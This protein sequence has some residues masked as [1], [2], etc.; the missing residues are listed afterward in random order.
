VIVRSRKK[1]LSSL[2]AAYRAE[3]ER[4]ETATDED[5]MSRLDFEFQRDQVLMEAVLD[6]REALSNLQEAQDTASESP[7]KSLLEK[8]QTLRKL[9]R[10]R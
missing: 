1:I 9:T 6:V 3:F 4:A 7:K 2:E 5:R 10:L 8:A